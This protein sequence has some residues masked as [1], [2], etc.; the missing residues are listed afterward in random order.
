[1]GGK[2]KKMEDRKKKR[3]KTQKTKS[4]KKNK[5]PKTNLSKSVI[6]HYH[7]PTIYN[8]SSIRPFVSLI[9]S[10]YLLLT[11]S[12]VPIGWCGAVGGCACAGRNWDRYLVKVF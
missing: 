9:S 4:T 10:S 7:H 6:Y 3:D 12:C 5:P 11:T 8:L 1:M 2:G